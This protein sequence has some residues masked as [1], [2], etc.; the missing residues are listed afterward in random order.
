MLS[1]AVLAG[2][3]K[4]GSYRSGKISPSM[5]SP[6][7]FKT[8]K[9]WKGDRVAPTGIERLR[10]NDGHYQEQE[11]VDDLVRAGFEIKDRQ[12]TLHIGSMVGH[13]DGLIL[14]DGKWCLFDCKAMSLN[15]YTRFKQRGFE[16]EPTIEVQMQLYLASDEL[17]KEGIDGGFVYAKHKDTC[18]PY[19]LFFE[20]DPELT[21]RL[22]EQVYSLL[23]G[24]VPVPVR[25]S[26]CPS[27]RERLDCWGAEVVDFSRVHTAS[28]PELVEQWKLGTNY[29][30]YGKELVEEAR[31]AFKK[32]LGDK[33]V[34]FI[35]DLKCLRVVQT[36]GGISQ[37]KF[38]EKY[39]AAALAD[40]WEDKPVPQMRVSE[41]E[42]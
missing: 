30:R 35:D 13:I 10:M 33:T 24:E 21:H 41:V 5:V 31:V 4:L 16:A 9:S 1:E 2:A 18:R 36:R 29:R 7:P 25:C 39:G 11:M 37:G 20:W 40:V 3:V 42:I 26:L 14:V 28:L 6:C 32:E 38:V 19:D 17:R 8:Y 15:R 27:C 12:S 22:E 23:N 34:V